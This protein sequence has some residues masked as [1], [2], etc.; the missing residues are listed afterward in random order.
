MR[1]AFLAST[2]KWGFP[3]LPKFPWVVTLFYDGLLTNPGAMNAMLM[4]DFLLAQFVM[5]VLDETITVPSTTVLAAW[6]TDP[7]AAESVR[8]VQIALA[9]QMTSTLL[10][11]LG[12]NRPPEVATKQIADAA[13]DALD[14][15][16]SGPGQVA[17]FRAAL[18]TSGVVVYPGDALT[19]DLA[20]L[21]AFIT[22]QL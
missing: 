4:N 6:Y 3:P 7:A 21:L 2:D 9:I 22:T 10:A 5:D 19:D 14:D 16:T 12:P 17:I 20:D 1:E 18:D 15:G 8:E 13:F 11:E